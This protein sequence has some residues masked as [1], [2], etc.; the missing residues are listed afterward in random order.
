MTLRPNS[1]ANP[2]C[3]TEQIHR[4][5]HCN[6]FCAECF[7]PRFC[8]GGNSER[9]LMC[10]NC[11]KRTQHSVIGERNRNDRFDYGDAKF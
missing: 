7:E 5:S 6:A 3:E 8:G 10:R 9:M 4:K 2:N 11:G 1:C